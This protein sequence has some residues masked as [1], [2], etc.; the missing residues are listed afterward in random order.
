MKTRKSKKLKKEKRVQKK[1]EE[2][3]IYIHVVGDVSHNQFPNP[4]NPPY[5]ITCAAQN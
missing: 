4:L 3:H 5:H 2:I 1:V